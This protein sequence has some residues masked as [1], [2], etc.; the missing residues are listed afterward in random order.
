MKIE[1]LLEQELLFLEQ[2]LLPHIW[3]EVVAALT[4]RGIQSTFVAEVEAI[5]NPRTIGGRFGKGLRPQDV[6]TFEL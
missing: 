3:L 6:A 1:E 4:S 5:D 2:Q